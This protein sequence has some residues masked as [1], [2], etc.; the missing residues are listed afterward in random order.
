MIDQGLLCSDAK[1]LGEIPTGSS[2]TEAPKE[3]G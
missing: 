2:R 3:K 1:G